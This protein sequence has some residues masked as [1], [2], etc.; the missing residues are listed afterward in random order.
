VHAIISRCRIHHWLR[1]YLD[2]PYVGILDKREKIH[3][4]L[5]DQRLGPEETLF[6]RRYAARHRDCPAR[7]DS[8]LPVL[9]GYN[10]LTQLREARPDVIVE[11]LR[12]F[13]GN[14]E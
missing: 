8:L 10:T 12:E 14:L 5:A 1:Q 2:K 3:E 4:I 13:A 7:R 9:T 11:H 6:I